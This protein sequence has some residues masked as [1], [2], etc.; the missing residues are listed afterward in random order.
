M[1][2]QIDIAVDQGV[3]APPLPEIEFLR[4][5][6]ASVPE[7]PPQLIEGI[8]HQRCKMVLGGTSQ[9]EQQVVVSAE[10]GG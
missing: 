7:P 1:S 8:L 2:E 10:P 9:Q 5:F 3:V 4:D 6:V